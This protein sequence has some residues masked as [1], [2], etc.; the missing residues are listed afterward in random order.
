ML[1]F[2]TDEGKK[3]DIDLCWV[4]HYG[5]FIQGKGSSAREGLRTESIRGVILDDDL[6]NLS[7]IDCDDLLSRDRVQQDAVLRGEWVHRRSARHVTW[8]SIDVSISRRLIL[9]W[10]V[11]TLSWLAGKQIKM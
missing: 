10:Q 2:L 6:N 9:G 7:E 4:L 3:D 8:Q 5:I 11:S 1:S